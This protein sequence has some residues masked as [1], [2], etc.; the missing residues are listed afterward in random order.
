MQSAF[1]LVHLDRL[2]AKT[3][4]RPEVRVGLI[5][6]VVEAGHP[7]LRGARIETHGEAGKS[8]CRVSS[9]IGCRHGTFIA[10]LLVGT[11]ELGI[12]GICPEVTLVSLPVFSD[13]LPSGSMP[14]VKPET[15]A[16]AIHKL[17]DAGTDVINLSVG[18]S[19]G[20]LRHVPDVF[21]AC[22]RA[23]EKGTLI[24]AATGNQ[25]RVGPVRL[26]SHEWVIPVASCLPDGAV[27]LRSNLGPSIGRR[28]LCAPSNA[29]SGATAPD[30]VGR[31]EGSSIATAFVT[32]TI[33]LLRS[34][35]PQLPAGSLR[36]ALLLEPRRWRSI[37]PPLLDAGKSLDY[38]G[39]R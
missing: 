17:V 21:D 35:H 38:L 33:A 5:D 1:E 20:S 3:R 12:H 6:G 15:V 24:V 14:S 31:M 30:G 4:G 16:D 37:V 27:D 23:Q 32:G 7:A 36:N 8:R 13:Q 10:S 26:F 29:I 34:L 19:A 2:M 39:T 22:A 11:G 28:G 18:I 25:G 9:S